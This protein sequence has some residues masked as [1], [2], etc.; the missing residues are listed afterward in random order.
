[1]KRATSKAL[2]LSVKEGANALTSPLHLVVV[3]AFMSRQRWA[4]PTAQSKWYSTRY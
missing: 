2:L 1:M 3:A 4:V